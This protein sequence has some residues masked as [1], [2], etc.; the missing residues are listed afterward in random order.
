MGVD[1]RDAW[2]KSVCWQESLLMARDPTARATTLVDGPRGVFRLHFRR[3]VDTLDA[4]RRSKVI[5]SVDFLSGDTVIRAR[6]NT[7]L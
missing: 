2:R 6:P 3:R 4:G 5:L 7:T 1:V